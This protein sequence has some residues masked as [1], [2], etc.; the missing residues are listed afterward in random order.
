MLPPILRISM[1]TGESPS[2]LV[3]SFERTGAIHL[4]GVLSP[5]EVMDLRRA[6]HAAFAPLDRRAP[7]DA[8]VR[9]LSAAMALRIAKVMEAIVHPRIVA[10]LKTILEPHYRIIPDFHIHRNLFDFTDTRRSVTHLFGLI[11]SG[12]HHDAGHEG[13]QDYLYDPRYRM[14]K[15][16]LYLQDNTFEY[17][18]GIATAP[19]GHKLPL[20]SGSPKINHVAQRLWQ[21][22]RILTGQHVLDIKAGDFVAFD[23]HLPH[24]GTQPHSLL[25]TVS[26]KERKTACVRLPDER[27]KLV[28]YF[29]ASRALLAD[30]Y[31]RHSLKR[32]RQELN[33][34]RS[35]TGEETFFS[36]FAGLR[37]PQD[38][39][40]EFVEALEANGLGM[41]QLTGEE[42]EDAVTQRRE[43]LAMPS[44]LNYHSVMA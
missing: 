34:L 42:L 24:R 1:T 7:G 19:A 14:V 22:F 15:C 33:E 2:E 6:I 21:N 43:A 25:R 41:S 12:W 40:R 26:E 23:C 16:G 13:A 30:T 32:G 35:G 39:P 37:Y 38:Y 29:N 27:A 28:I 20:R 17:G 9:A 18:G 8:L 5:E 11:G 36:D 10:A 31:L 3:R 4:R 44:L